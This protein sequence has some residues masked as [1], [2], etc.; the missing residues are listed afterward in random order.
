MTP[1]VA[2]AK[3][4]IADTMLT[5]EAFVSRAAED[6]AVNP[7][8][9]TLGP[10][11]PSLAGVRRK[12]DQLGVTLLQ[13]VQAARMAF[14]VHSHEL[15]RPHLNPDHHDMDVGPTQESCE[16]CRDAQIHGRSLQADVLHII[17][18]VKFDA[19][20][21][22][23]RAAKETGKSRDQLLKEWRTSANDQLLAKVTTWI[24]DSSHA[25]HDAVAYS[26]IKPELRAKL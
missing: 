7:H 14:Y 2:Q 11:S 8:D 24:S 25:V 12:L 17:D 3:E 4:A 19:T 23:D 16:A 26:L 10:R 21:V 20:R 13:I 9:F 1:Y 18:R 5:V 15:I 6:A 22:I